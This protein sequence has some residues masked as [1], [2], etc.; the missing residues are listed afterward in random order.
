MPPAGCRGFFRE[1]EGGAIEL[2]SLDCGSPVSDEWQSCF[3][4]PPDS[5]AFASCGCINPDA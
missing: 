2:L 3:E 4:V 5:P 1:D